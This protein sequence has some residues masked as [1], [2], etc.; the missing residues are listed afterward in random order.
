MLLCL[1]S[2]G[3]SF[4]QKNKN[5]PKWV[6]YEERS[7]QFPERVY[8]IGFTSEGNNSSEQ[9]EEMFERLKGYSRIQLVESVYTTIKSLTT[10]DVMTEN[11]ETLE[12]FRQTSV[13]FSKINISG[14]TIETYYDEK[15]NTS[16]AFAY[17][18]K[19]KL[20]ELYKANIANSKTQI[21]MNLK[22]AKQ[23][24]S[25]GD[26]QNALKSF[27]DCYPV[28]RDIEEAQTM[29][30]AFE[31]LSAG[32]PVLFAQEINNLKVDVCRGIKSLQQ[33][34]NLTLD[35]VCYIIANA[36]DIQTDEL[37][38]PV[39]LVN[40]TFEDSKMGSAFSK[41]LVKSLEQKL[42]RTGLQ[43]TTSPTSIM[44]DN[45]KQEDSYLLT[46]TYWE[47]GNN[48]KIISILRSTDSGKAIASAES[49]L[50]LKWLKT[51]NIAYKPDNYNEAIKNLMEFDKQVVLNNGGLVIDVSTNKG[52]ENPIFV[53]DEKLILYVKANKECY[54][55]FIYHLA[56]KS[57]VL[58]YD[59]YFI[60]N[61]MANKIIEIPQH[62][63]CAEPFGVETLQLNAQ[64]EEF[65]PLNIAE[66]FGYKFIVDDLEDVL[67][68]TRGFKP[69]KNEDA[70]AE[71]R[72]IITTLAE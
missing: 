15:N 1:F 66:E 55:R 60:P 4:S 33:G 30:I 61:S 70:K 48:L 19:D 67:K 57:K 54:L 62:F 2:A 50:P 38:K 44:G 51:N 69:V 59:N 7:K 23:F 39:R 45:D 52:N 24:I 28:F 17:A 26:K 64:S 13:S 58:F 65:L 40:F 3:N 32:D 10:T 8:L 56:D 18:E 34:G 14:L 49:T 11:T 37:E 27:Y 42:I 29:L 68:N 71:K 9:Q 46:G 25:A 12:L 5:K 31:R 16:Y 36:I 47:E 20:S 53:K 21:E 35:D 72:L 41:R 22:N 6:S 43:I 63:Y